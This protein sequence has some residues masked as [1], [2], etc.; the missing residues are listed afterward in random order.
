MKAV[1]RSIFRKLLF[2][3]RTAREYPAVR[4]SNEEVLEKVTLRF[5]SHTVDITKTHAVVCQ[6][7]FYMAIWV[8]PDTIQ[9]YLPASY[10]VSIH[11]GTKL[12][13][14]LEANLYHIIHENGLSIMVLNLQ[15]GRSFLINYPQQQLLLSYFVRKRNITFREGAIYGALY[16]YPRRV[17]VVSYREQEYF[18]IFPMDFQCLLEDK[19]L[20]FFGLRTTNITLQKIL[21]AKKLVV[22]NTDTVDL[23]T[24][25]LLGKHHSSVPPS[26]ETL[27]FQ[28]LESEVYK[29]PVPSF[30]SAYKEVEVLTSF[31][32]GTHTFFVGKV[33]NS[34]KVRAGS[35]SIYHFHFFG[36]L[37]ASYPEIQ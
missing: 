18:N 27:P 24:I 2:K 7:P 23:S 8:E 33:V 11:R 19:G 29:F 34:K 1:F 12:I 25:Y 21:T 6:T 35:S 14:K 37:E 16:S 5:G 9:N 4:I 22:S 31:P 30:S 28:L 32:L 10:E 3:N 20:Y 17:I 13:A 36:S 15:Q 26:P